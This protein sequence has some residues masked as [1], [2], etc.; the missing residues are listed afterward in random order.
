MYWASFEAIKSKALNAMPALSKFLIL[1]AMFLSASYAHAFIS[2]SPVAGN[3]AQV[4]HLIRF[5]E[6]MSDPTVANR[7]ANQPNEWIWMQSF[8]TIFHQ[9]NL[10]KWTVNQSRMQSFQAILLPLNL[11]GPAMIKN[12]SE[13]ET[14][15]PL[16]LVG[17]ATIKNQSK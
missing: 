8:Q 15:L 10:E 9:R 16:N 13:M 3:Q 4:N 6:S 7:F 1:L 17:F 2:L 14:V 5:E 11:M 12:Q